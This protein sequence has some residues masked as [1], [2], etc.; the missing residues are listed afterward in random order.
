M[1]SKKGGLESPG[2]AKSR[3]KTFE[4]NL[5]C[6]HR[7]ALTYASNQPGDTPKMP[8]KGE[9]PY[10][11]AVN[12]RYSEGMKAIKAAIGL[13]KAAAKNQPQKPQ[14][15]GQKAYDKTTK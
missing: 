14:D 15:I 9:S 7:L 12:K 5:E 2:K 10:M 11:K 13:G 8:S 3:I 4:K 6:G 1:R